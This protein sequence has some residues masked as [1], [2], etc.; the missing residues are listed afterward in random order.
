L[1]VL[2]F[3]GTS[4]GSAARVRR[5]AR[6]VRA[7]VRKGT[8]VVVVVSATGHTTDRI[9]QRVHAVTRSG[10]PLDREFDRALA[11]GEDLSAALFACALQAISIPARSLRGGEAG[12]GAHGE[13][14]A[15]RLATLDP[16][17]VRQLLAQG[18]VPVVTGFQA[19]RAD[20]ETVT[21]GRGGSD[22]S[23][24]FLAGLLNADACHII[25]DVAAV[26]D[27]DPHLHPDARPL[28]QL[29]HTELVDITE[30]GGI[31]VQPA[32]ARWAQELS[33][34]LYVYHYSAAFHAHA[35][36]EIRAAVAARRAS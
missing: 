5:A 35:G 3:G 18:V 2:K 36:T 23:A 29:T 9:V 28:P 19:V 26:C 15:G 10:H 16:A 11:T 1:I 32:A 22:A 31:V 24:V 34:P 13:F 4:L 21:L 14:G 7:H 6:R 27:S 30:A 25:T 12:L 20:G 33:T 17:P 8:R